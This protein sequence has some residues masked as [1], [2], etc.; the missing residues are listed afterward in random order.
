VIT[1]FPSTS[2]MVWGSKPTGLNSAIDRLDKAV[3]EL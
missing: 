2:A 1:V 3:D